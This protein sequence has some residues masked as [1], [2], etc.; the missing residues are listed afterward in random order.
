[1]SDADDNEDSAPLLQRGADTPASDGSSCVISSSSG[2]GLLADNLSQGS[3]LAVK[4]Q[5]GDRG[6]DSSACS[7]ITTAE[8]NRE[9]GAFGVDGYVRGD[10]YG[11]TAAGNGGDSPSNPDQP[12][13]LDVLGSDI[14]AIVTPVSIC[15]LLVVLL[16]LALTPHGS[17]PDIPTIGTLVYQEKT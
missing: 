16:V 2:K 7:S 15:M 4:A 14:I 1:M 3:S 6:S 5:G 17:A 8:K 11:S 9:N 13:I 10:G 12:T